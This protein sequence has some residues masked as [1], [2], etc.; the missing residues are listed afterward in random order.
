MRTDWAKSI[1]DPTEGFRRPEDDALAPRPLSLDGLVLGLLDNGK[2]NG[3][4]L[5]NRLAAALG[6]TFHLAEVRMWTKENA[7]VTLSPAMLEEIRSRCD[8]VVTAIGDCGSCSAA[9][10]AD[11]ILLER[12]G[13]PTVSIC[14][15]AFTFSADAMAEVYGFPSYKYATIAHPVASLSVQELDERA[16][17]SVSSVL[18]ILGMT[19]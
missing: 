2:A 10:T 3:S 16:A 6:S 14:S 19:K 15:D 5:L 13:V 18:K 8:V 11:G 7:G 4:L 17:D 12:A 9:T 1:V